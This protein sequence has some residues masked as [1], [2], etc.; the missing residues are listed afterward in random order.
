MEFLFPEYTLDPYQKGKDWLIQYAQA[1]ISQQERIPLSRFAGRGTRLNEIRAYAR[2]KQSTDIYMKALKINEDTSEDNWFSLDYTPLPLANKF[3]KQ[4]LGL[5]R[6][7]DYNVEAQVVDNLSTQESD[8][9]IRKVRNAVQIKDMAR[10]KGLEIADD[11]AFDVVDDQPYSFDEMEIWEKYSY[12]HRL[13]YEFEVASSHVFRTNKIQDLRTRW[14]RDLFDWGMAIGR[15]EVID[16]EVRIRYVDPRRFVVSRCDNN[17]FSDMV[18]AGEVMTVP[19]AK[20]REMAGDQFSEV[21]YQ[22]IAKQTNPDKFAKLS[23]DSRY[24]MG[25]F[26]DELK[27]DLLDLELITTDK[28]VYKENVNKRG[29]KVLVKAPYKEIEK[30]RQGST[31]TQKTRSRVYKIRHILGTNFAFDYG[32]CS[33]QKRRTGDPYQVSLSYHAVAYEMEDMMPIGVMELMIPVIDQMQLNWLKV[34]QC[35]IS[36][37]PKGFAINAGALEDVPITNGGTDMRPE[38]LIKFFVRH[39]VLVYRQENIA[40]VPVNGIP[41]TEMMNGVDPSIAIYWSNVNNCVNMLRDITGLNPVTD[42]S[43]INPKMLTTPTQMAGAAT[44]NALSGIIE[45]DERLLLS[46]AEGSIMRVQSML[47]TGDVYVM[48]LGKETN[49]IL[50]L[51]K[52]L[53]LREFGISLN[54]RPT[55]DDKNILIAEAKNLFGADM[56]DMSDIFFIKNLSNLKAAEALLSVR[57]EQKRRKKMEESMML[58]QQNAQVQMQSA[59]AS[60]QAKQQTIQVEKDLELRNMTEEYKLKAMLKQMEL[61]VKQEMGDADRLIKAAGV[62]SQ[63]QIAQNDS[64]ATPEEAPMAQ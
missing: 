1:V 42:G 4:A 9:L 56:V 53:S 15:D 32:L 7:Y 55:D 60:E 59:A 54:K 31:Y 49:K 57:I 5:L 48:A 6:D 3:R 11:E 62:Q 8:E 19:I 12:K 50:S 28:V 29:N 34:Q 10:K 40:G 41:I 18:Y 39:G 35:L 27:V 20:L 23:R 13:A 45:A 14:K 2:G 43:S 63:M 46:L 61:G 16:N 51:S 22:D 17:D 30:P 36:A 37:R 21:D 26:Y 38:D 64:N 25:R 58:Q 52:D 33:H 47:M 24:R 44:N